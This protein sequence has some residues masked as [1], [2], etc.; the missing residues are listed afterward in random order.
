[1]TED[2]RLAPPD[3]MS[4]LDVMAE[5]L[6]AL[7]YYSFDANRGRLPTR[8]EWDAFG[9]PN[10]MDNA[11]FMYN[12]AAQISFAK[13]DEAGGLSA[14]TGIGKIGNV[15]RDA[16]N[17]GDDL[18]RI[19]AENISKQG[20]KMTQ[21]QLAQQI[22][23]SPLVDLEEAIYNPAIYEVETPEFGFYGGVRHSHYLGQ[24]GGLLSYQ[25]QKQHAEEYGIRP[26]GF[27]MRNS[28]RFIVTKEGNEL[29]ITRAI[30]YG[31]RTDM[32]SAYY[33]PGAFVS[34]SVP[35]IR[36]LQSGT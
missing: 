25:L 1:M 35:Q 31:G 33:E 28:D 27:S 20:Q 17:T 18:L 16:F 34:G 6:K 21:R 23:K 13:E 24:P 29:P 12:P 36:P 15:V 14:F 2:E 19:S 11:L 22:N 30:D 32:N 4:L 9:S 8:A 5:P 3:Q 10:P 7:E 26:E